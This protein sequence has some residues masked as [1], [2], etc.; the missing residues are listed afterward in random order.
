M[1]ARFA[2]LVLLAQKTM[3][4]D[5]ENLDLITHSYT[6][7]FQGR[8]LHAQARMFGSFIDDPVATQSGRGLI[9]MRLGRLRINIRQL[10]PRCAT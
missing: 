8:N 2:F 3:L 10:A 4:S 7:L 1:I 6:A 5:L 9:S